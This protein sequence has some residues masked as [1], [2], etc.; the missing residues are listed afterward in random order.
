MTHRPLT[1]ALSA[2]AVFSAGTG[3]GGLA[4]A[5][6]LSEVLGPPGWAIRLVGAGLLVF[7]G[8]V[9]LVAR[10]AAR[11]G[12]IQVVMADAGWIVIAGALVAIGPDWLSEAGRL[13][14]GGLTMV[15]VVL[16]RAQWRGL[17]AAS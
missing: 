8:A 1:N 7:A 6:G 16:A 11:T 5:N 12:V 14:L 17:D 13:T 15:V 4:F 10:R 9:A 3:L 2:N